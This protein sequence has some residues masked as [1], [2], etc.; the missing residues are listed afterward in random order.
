MEM[1]F[2]KSFLDHKVSFLFDGWFNT[3]KENMKCT[4]IL[5]IQNDRMMFDDV[6][7]NSKTPIM[8]FLN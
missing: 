1:Q 7:Y 8:I 6:I 2:N 5:W 4:G 3:R